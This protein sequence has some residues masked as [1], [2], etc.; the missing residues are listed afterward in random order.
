MLTRP[1]TEADLLAL[2]DLCQAYDL[3]EIGISDL[4]V[5]DLRQMLT[6]PEST[7][8]VALAVDDSPD[9]LG[10]AHLD[11]DGDAETAVDPA[12]PDPGSL[13]RSLV[14]FVLEDARRRALSAV[15]HWSG[16][17][18]GGAGDLLAEVGFSHVRSSW[19][20]HAQP[21][22]AVAAPRW[23]AGV[24]LRPLDRERDV[25]EVWA[26]VQQHFAGMYGSRPRSF[27]S[28][29]ER[30]LVPGSDVA[31]AVDGDQLIGV[32]V[33]TEHEDHGY[34][35]QLV[36]DS[37]QRGRG[38]G[39]ALLTSVI[40]RNAAK[41]KATQLNVDGTNDRAL[42]LYRSVGMQIDAEFRQWERSLD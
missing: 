3:V 40:A 9:L 2:T 42:A 4:D 16:A 39:L 24:E 28:W 38:I 32:A 34:L 19:R 27:D 8:E 41:G 25:R 30:F 23:P 33:M 7:N 18:P 10:F 37:A 22:G 5:E 35:A 17:G 11:P 21:G 29:C 12:G 26:F 36:V 31:C 20:M 6:I 14:A 13:Q 1:A 15:T